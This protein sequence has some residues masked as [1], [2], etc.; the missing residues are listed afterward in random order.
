MGENSIEIDIDLVVKNALKAIDQLNQKFDSLEDKTKKSASAWEVFEGVL[1][2]SGV[3]K[4]LEKMWQGAEKL[5]D[6]FIVEGVKAAGELEDAIQIMNTALI[7]SG[8]WSEEASHKMDD[9]S[10]SL[11]KHSKFSKDAILNRCA[12]LAT[13]IFLNPAFSSNCRR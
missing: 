9:F 3:E 12:C 4:I 2:A 5:F 1:A 7:S 8:K 10:T 11:M 6:V 13:S